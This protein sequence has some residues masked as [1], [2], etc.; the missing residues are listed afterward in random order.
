MP[1]Y[2]PY[3]YL[4]IYIYALSIMLWHPYVCTDSPGTVLRAGSARRRGRWTMTG[5]LKD[6]VLEAFW[7][8]VLVSSF[9]RLL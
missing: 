8:A 4:S 5:E 9:H 3:V 1:I 7:A 6:G 2:D